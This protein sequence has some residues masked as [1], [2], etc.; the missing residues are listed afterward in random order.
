MGK[1]EQAFREAFDRLKKGEPLRVAKG[2]KISQNLVAKE[3]GTDSTA[4]KKARFPSLVAE[5]QQWVANNLRPT[6]ASARQTTIKQ[7][8]KNRTYR[9]QIKDL[10]MQRDLVASQ[11]VEA[12][13]KILELTLDLERLRAAPLPE[14]VIRI[15]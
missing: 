12:D 15:R 1:A 5:I 3:A 13:A 2:A 8:T 14:K 9:E 11:L 6:I 10:K 4:L 7:R